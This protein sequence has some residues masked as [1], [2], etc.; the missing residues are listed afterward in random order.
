MRPAGSTLRRREGG[1]NPK[2]RCSSRVVW[3]FRRAEDGAE[4]L[5]PTHGFLSKNQSLGFLGR[6]S[7]EQPEARA[8]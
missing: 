5:G 7:Q 2:G 3:R 8:M 1:V 6:D 4:S